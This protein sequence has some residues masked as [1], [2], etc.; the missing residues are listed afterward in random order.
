MNIGYYIKKNKNFFDLSMILYLH[1]FL[2]DIK[3]MIY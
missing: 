1:L 3:K 2:I